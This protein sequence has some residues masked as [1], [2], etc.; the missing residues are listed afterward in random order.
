[1][2]YYGL[3]YTCDDDD[4]DHDNHDRQGLHTRRQKQTID[5]VLCIP[6][7]PVRDLKITLSEKIKKK[8]IRM[9]Q[10]KFVE[11][12]RRRLEIFLF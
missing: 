6:S 5:G 1:M 10:K 2:P 4:D 7:T 3:M 11:K 9:T 12:R 8:K